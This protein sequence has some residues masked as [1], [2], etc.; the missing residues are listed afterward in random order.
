MKKINDLD[1][2]LLQ[3]KYKDNIDYALKKINEDYPI[4]YLIG[5]VDFYGYRINVDER[6]L[7]PRYE[8]EYLLEKTINYIH[9]Y[10]LENSNVLD[11]GTGSGCI[12]IV[13][14]KKISSLNIDTIDISSDALDVAR[15]NYKINNVSINIINEDIKKYKTTKKYSIIISNPPYVSNNE[16]V[17]PEIKYEPKNAIYASNNGLEYYDYILNNISNNLTNHYLIAMEIAYNQGD[18]L[19]DLSRSIFKDANV[20][21]EKDLSNRDRYLFIIK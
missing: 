12:D 10:K 2:K 6:V 4:Q 17:G 1:Y 8:T 14:K 3:D 15:E 13:L 5:Y 11:I 9:K 19:Y 7:I 21:I 20:A 16:V 18:Y